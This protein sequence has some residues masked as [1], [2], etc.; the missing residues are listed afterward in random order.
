MSPPVFGYVDTS[1]APVSSGAGGT[2]GRRKTVTFQG[3]VETIESPP[4]AEKQQQPGSS[5]A[6][7]AQGQAGDDYVESRV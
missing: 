1:A 6:K 2:M 5:S 3:D 4:A 7:D